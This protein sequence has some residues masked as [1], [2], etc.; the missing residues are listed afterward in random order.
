VI[1]QKFILTGKEQ[2]VWTIIK[3]KIRNNSARFFLSSIIVQTSCSLPVSMNFWKITQ[4]I[5][6][7]FSWSYQFYSIFNFYWK[8]EHYDE[9][10]THTFGALLQ[11]KFK[12]FHRHLWK[13]R[14]RRIWYRRLLNIISINFF[15]RW[16]F[17]FKLNLKLITR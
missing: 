4:K 15:K 7:F 6:L 16:S 3:I 8:H 5:E 9:F 2:L 1:F 11:Q 17:L 13:L 14:H 12:S 10:T